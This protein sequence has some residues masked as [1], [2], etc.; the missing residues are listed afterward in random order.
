MPCAR[1]GPASPPGE[2]VP[3]VQRPREAWNWPA[4]AGAG[5]PPAR[6]GPGPG[7]V[8]TSAAG[9]LPEARGSA[10]GAV[11]WGAGSVRAVHSSVSSHPAEGRASLVLMFVF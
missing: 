2:E 5:R 6:P 8:M 9:P 4:E 1:L 10:W 11:A 3:G 7:L